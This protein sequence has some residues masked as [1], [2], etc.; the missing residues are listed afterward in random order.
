MASLKEALPV[1]QQFFGKLDEMNAHLR[2]SAGGG[3]AAFYFEAKRYMRA[4]DE[5][6]GLRYRPSVIT[7][8]SDQTA[9]AGSADFRVA[10]NEDFLVHSIRGFVSLPDLTSQAAVAQLGGSLAGNT[11]VAD[12]LLAKA[13][14]CRLTLLNKD[15]KVPITENE[16]I[17]LADISPMVGGESMRFQPDAVPGFIIPHNMTL[18]AQFNLQNTA[19]VYSSV[20]TIYGVSLSGVYVSREVR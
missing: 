2:Q 16:G 13:Q 1:I 5:Q 8:S 14:N 4:F 3:I 20:S 17:S 12:I 10:Q 15:S 11:S 7:L 18:Q 6:R 19:N 9:A